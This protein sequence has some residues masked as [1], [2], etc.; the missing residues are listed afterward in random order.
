MKVAAFNMAAGGRLCTPAPDDKIERTYFWHHMQ[1]VDPQKLKPGESVLCRIEAPEPGGY[2]VTLLPGDLQGFLPSQ[3]PIDIGRVVPATFVCMSGKRALMAYAFMIGT[4]ERVQ[5]STATD[6]ENAFAVWADSYP[7]AIKLRRAIDLIVPPLH[8]D[9]LHKAKASELDLSSYFQKLES[10]QFNGCIRVLSHAQKSR[11]A[12]LFYRGRAVGGIYS[13]KPMVD[14]Y[15]IETAVALLL[16]DLRLPDAELESYALP[17]ELVLAMSALFLGCIVKRA[18]TLTNE[19]YLE[20][21]LV[22]LATRADTACLSLHQDT[23]PLCL[24][25][26]AEGKL[27]GTY[28]IMERKYAANKDY[29]LEVLGKDDSGKLE[30]YILPSVMVSDSVR[31]GFSLTSEQFAAHLKGT[32]SARSVNAS[33][34]F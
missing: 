26:I 4:T 15:P 20:K 22:E 34:D 10:D 17:D 3:D 24:G 30:A 1:P 33:H 29:L 7:K 14:P 11:A 18:D 25:L 27:L 16:G 5:L 21:V 12:A 8:A 6:S 23:A 31:F 13:K 19:Q 9:D 2:T 32:A 28:S